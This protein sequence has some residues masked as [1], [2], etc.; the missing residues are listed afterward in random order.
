MK[1]FVPEQFVKSSEDQDDDTEGSQSVQEPWNT[2]IENPFG[3]CP[4]PTFD[5]QSPLFA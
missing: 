2:D 4:D 5:T 1:T 3:V